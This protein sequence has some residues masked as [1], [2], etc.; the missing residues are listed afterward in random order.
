MY[1][2]IFEQLY[3]GSMIG[4][5]CPVFAVWGYVIA[6]MRE[7]TEV[8]A[9]VELNPQLLGYILGAKE[10][11]VQKAIDYLCAPDPRS[12]TKE[13]EGRRLV[14]QGQ[15]AYQVVNGAK[16]L[17]IRNA[18]QK[19]ASDRLRKQKERKLKKVGST[20]ADRLYQKALA[21]GDDQTV[22]DLD[23]MAGQVPQGKTLCEVFE[24]EEK[25]IVPRGTVSKAAQS[26]EPEASGLPVRNWQEELPE[27]L[28]NSETDSHTPLRKVPEDT[29][30]PTT[31]EPPEDALLPEELE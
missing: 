8:G 7:D 21:N 1:G 20:A 18:E 6:N 19:R 24:A 10:A 2:R 17:A 26:P 27:A 28:A 3:T 22:K 9:Q 4:A 29:E 12:R 14:Q 30:C 5:G 25:P 11:E 16:Y 23:R 13:L 15:F 31:R